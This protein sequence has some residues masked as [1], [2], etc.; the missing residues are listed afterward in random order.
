MHKAH[1]PIEIYDLW[2]TLSLLFFLCLNW[3]AKCLVRQ[4]CYLIELAVLSQNLVSQLFSLI[5]ILDN[6]LDAHLLHFLLAE[7]VP[8]NFCHI[9]QP[10]RLRLL[11]DLFLDFLAGEQFP[12][13]FDKLGPLG[14]R[15]VVLAGGRLERGFDLLVL[16]SFLLRRDCTGSLSDAFFRKKGR[17]LL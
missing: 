8:V 17:W 6:V 12:L 7:I 15:Q 10:N 13:T 1:F 4:V 11:F 16:L 3:L 14:L 9:K 2:V 5:R